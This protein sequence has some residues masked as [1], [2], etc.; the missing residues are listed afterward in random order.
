MQ[1]RWG[2]YEGVYWIK[3]ARLLSLLKRRWKVPDDTSLMMHK[4]QKGW[5]EDQCVRGRMRMQGDK[6]LLNWTVP[7][8]SKSV[9][10]WDRLEK[11]RS[12]GGPFCTMTNLLSTYR[13]S[14]LQ[15]DRNKVESKF[16]KRTAPRPFVVVMAKYDSVKDVWLP[17]PALLIWR[18][19]QIKIS[20]EQACTMEKWQGRTLSMSE[21]GNLV[22]TYSGANSCKEVRVCDYGVCVLN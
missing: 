7:L 3:W 18:K 12:E 21:D 19:I 15:D 14:W 9:K 22:C 10:T 5:E 1:R 13:R 20:A 2:L 8:K 11:Q 17:T 6:F 4:K 16:P